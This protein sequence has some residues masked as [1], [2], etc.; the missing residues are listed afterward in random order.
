MAVECDHSLL[1]HSSLTLGWGFWRIHLA[2]LLLNRSGA[3]DPR[4]LQS[5]ARR[6]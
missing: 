5:L 4:R 6:E 2:V 3:R 1:T